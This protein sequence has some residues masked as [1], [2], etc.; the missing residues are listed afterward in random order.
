MTGT[1]VRPGSA[2]RN[3]RRTSRKESIRLGLIPS[4]YTIVLTDEFFLQ[5]FY[6]RIGFQNQVF[7]SS[8][9]QKYVHK[10]F[11]R[12][13]DHTIQSNQMQTVKQPF[14]G[15]VVIWGQHVRSLMGHGCKCHALDGPYQEVPK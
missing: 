4:V 14:F 13:I 11:P 15:N 3:T 6:F 5:F 8:R 7:K 10:V 1:W 12:I 2:A 9:A